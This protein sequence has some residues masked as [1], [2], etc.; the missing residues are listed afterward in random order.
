MRWVGFGLFVCS[1]I[2]FITCAVYYTIFKQIFLDTHLS[3][4]QFLTRRHPLT[5]FSPFLW[6]VMIMME[7]LIDRIKGTLRGKGVEAH[8]LYVFACT[9]Y[10]TLGGVSKSHIFLL[11]AVVKAVR[12]EESSYIFEIQHPLAHTNLPTPT[13]TVS[14]G[15]F[16]GI[17]GLGFGHCDSV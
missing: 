1:E 8:L 3:G 6:V 11:P 2:I 16:L 10:E 12:R 15:R 9:A 4:R 14:H 5:P 13:P 17:L 7:I